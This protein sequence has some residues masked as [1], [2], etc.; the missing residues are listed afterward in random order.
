MMVEAVLLV[1]GYGCQWNG[2]TGEDATPHG[3]SSMNYEVCRARPY[4]KT[5]KTTLHIVHQ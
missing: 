4:V 1:G 5:D 3:S 2:V